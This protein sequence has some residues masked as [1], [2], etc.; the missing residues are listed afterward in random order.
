MKETMFRAAYPVTF[1]MTT[2]LL[3][4]ASVN[5]VSSSADAT[6][7]FLA[8]FD[9]QTEIATKTKLNVRHVPG[10]V[11]VLYGATLRKRGY[12]TVL[13]AL[14]RIPGFQVLTNSYK[15]NPNI[16]GNISDTTQGDI[17]ILLNGVPQ[18]S[19]NDLQPFTVLNMPLAN[20]SRVEVIKGPGSALY[21]EYAL[22][23][24]INIVTV[25]ETEGG[26]ANVSHGSFDSYS[27]AVSQRFEG[28]DWYFSISAQTV[29]SDGYEPL[30]QEDLSVAEGQTLQAKTPARADTRNA[31]ESFTLQGQYAETRFDI[32]YV[33]S[34]QGD[35]F[36]ATARLTDSD[37]YKDE[38]RSEAFQ[39]TQ[40]LGKA[41]G[42][43]LKL[44]A[45]VQ[46]HHF[47][48]RL[49]IVPKGHCSPFS[50]LS[51][52]F[53]SP[54]P[55]QQVAGF[56]VQPQPFPEDFYLDTE[57]TVQR[58]YGRLQWLNE[59]YENHRVLV[60][61]VFQHIDVPETRDTSNFDFQAYG[62]VGV[63]LSQIATR[64]FPYYPQPQS[65]DR[66]P[67]NTWSLFGV[68]KESYSIVLQDEVQ[69]T[70]NTRI[71]AGIRWD[72][73]ER[74]DHT[75]SPRLALSHQLYEN[76]WMK[77][78]LAR[79]FRPPSLHQ[80]VSALN[81]DFEKM[82]TFDFKY[83]HHHDRWRFDHIAY[84]SWV[85]N[86]IVPLFTVSGVQNLDETGLFVNSQDQY[87]YYGFE[88]T[89]GFQMSENLRFE[90]NLAHARGDGP[91]F[92]RSA[93]FVSPTTV[94]VN[95]TWDVN[96]FVQLFVEHRYW[97]PR[98]RRPDDSRQGLGSQYL[99]NVSMSMMPL[100]DDRMVVTV[101]VDNVFDRSI[102]AP[103][104]WGNPDSFPNDLPLAP[105][106]VF[107]SAEYRW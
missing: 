68:E 2:A 69:L 46:R 20:V 97:G 75:Y 78:Q 52:T 66:I 83:S 18:V 10:V 23:G 15:S 67:Y 26:I 103:S 48:R 36:G 93:F 62:Q 14:T 11:D 16:R 91:T 42:G 92:Q 64:T 81:L 101:S 74:K 82:D 96:Q 104:G 89:V 45:G 79:A 84:V 25:V 95:M 27:A 12:H 31:F 80:E 35:L 38:V 29:Q 102:K 54:C 61:A 88:N 50:P 17:Q 90:S 63:D 55:V 34:L 3:C 24:V 9:A 4:S 51:F 105:R 37:D 21:G 7:D 107:A 85:N 44:F 49:I 41:A 77:F 47:D 86:K 5:A 22:V 98:K 99:T 58:S 76:Q 28:D 40:G 87:R 6:P 106:R 57:S 33:S 100:N 94:D 70:K 39:L 59:S 72:D 19:G 32:S 60:E 8:M 65:F 30:V 13:D 43:E 73:F 56:T 71:T 53:T 1:V